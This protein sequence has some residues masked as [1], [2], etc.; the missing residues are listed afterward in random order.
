MYLNDHQ[1]AHIRVNSR[2]A[3]YYLSS[4]SR[5]TYCCAPWHHL[6]QHLL[7]SPI[8][9]P[10]LGGYLFDHTHRRRARRVFASRA[11]CGSKVARCSST[12]AIVSSICFARDFAASIGLKAS[13]TRTPSTLIFSSRATRLHLRTRSRLPAPAHRLDVARCRRLTPATHQAAP[14]A[15]RPVSARHRHHRPSGSL[16]SNKAGYNSP[17]PETLRFRARAC[18]KENSASLERNGTITHWG[19]INALDRIVF[20]KREYP[21]D[22]VELCEQLAI[23]QDRY[24]VERV[25]KA[26]ERSLFL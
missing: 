12:T 9:S 6:P 14:A 11:R 13:A 1:P 22:A 24:S 20:F 25:A 5:T 10:A 3:H 4:P 8:T 26:L 2:G 23:G 19:G 7:Y 21:D 16:L 17:R 18:R 15:L